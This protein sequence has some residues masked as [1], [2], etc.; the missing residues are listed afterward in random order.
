MSRSENSFKNT[1]TASMWNWCLR[2]CGLWISDEFCYRY[3]H[4]ITAGVSFAVLS[5]NITAFLTDGAILHTL[6]RLYVCDSE[7]SWAGQNFGLI[8]RRLLT[9]VYVRLKVKRC[10]CRSHLRAAGCKTGWKTVLLSV[11]T[12]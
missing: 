6:R 12:P 4:R 2:D 11:H 8:F 9:K 1:L 7:R 5:L 3:Q 10:T